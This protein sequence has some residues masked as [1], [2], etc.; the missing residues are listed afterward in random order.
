MSNK[1]TAYER[2]VLERAW[3]DL[4]Y[5]ISFIVDE[6]SEAKPVLQAALDVVQERLQRKED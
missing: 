4:E 2:R 5:M 6:N 1:L 3:M